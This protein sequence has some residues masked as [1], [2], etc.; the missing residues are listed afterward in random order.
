MHNLLYFFLKKTNSGAIVSEIYS[1]IFTRM[2]SLF[3][4]RACTLFFYAIW[5][6]A[7]IFRRRTVHR[8]KKVSFGQVRLCQIKLGQIRLGQ[9]GLV[10]FG[11]V[12]FSI[13]TASCPYGKLSYGEKSQSHLCYTCTEIFRA[14]MMLRPPRGMRHLAPHGDSAQEHALYKRHVRIINV[15][16]ILSVNYKQSGEIYKYKRE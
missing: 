13:F 15:D 11:Q 9:L 10:R 7:Q 6:R 4:A 14:N 1:R 5:A 3:R 8:K 16:C 12:F 2:D